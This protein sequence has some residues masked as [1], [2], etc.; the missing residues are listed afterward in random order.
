MT[1]IRLETA[2]LLKSDYG[3]A[4]SITAELFDKGIICEPAA[5]NVLIKSEY[6]RRMQPKEKQRIRNTIAER[7][8]VSVKL[9]E[10]IVLNKS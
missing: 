5:R 8:C 3:I 10:K 6:K 9:V 1:N 7:Y 4:E 2:K